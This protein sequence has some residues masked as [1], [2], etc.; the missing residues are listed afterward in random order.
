M[1]SSGKMRTEDG[2]AASTEARCEP[3]NGSQLSS[4]AARW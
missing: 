2:V 1:L 4:R 3:S